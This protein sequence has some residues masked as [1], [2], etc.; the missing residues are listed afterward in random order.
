MFSHVPPEYQPGLL[1]VLHR[2]FVQ[3]RNL[4]L[5]GDCQ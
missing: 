3:A 5:Q 2:A 4:A 1:R